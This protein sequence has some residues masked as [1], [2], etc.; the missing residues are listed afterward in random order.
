MISKT[1]GTCG[2]CTLAPEPKEGNL[3]FQCRRRPPVAML[4]PRGVDARGVLSMEVVPVW[5][6]V[7]ARDGTMGCHDWI[8]NA[9]LLDS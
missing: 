5:P 2:A 7:D 9:E 1:C 8:G 3:I 4:M 6:P